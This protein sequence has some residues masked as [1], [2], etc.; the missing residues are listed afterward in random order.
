MLACIEFGSQFTMSIGR[1]GY[2]TKAERPAVRK[3]G[4]VNGRGVRTETVDQHVTKG[5]IVPELA[6]P[7]TCRVEID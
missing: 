7:I 2:P 3:T 1:A 6:I 5:G 4:K